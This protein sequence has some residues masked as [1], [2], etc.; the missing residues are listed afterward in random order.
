MRIHNHN[1][2]TVLVLGLKKKRGREP[3]LVLALDFRLFIKKLL[4][5]MTIQNQERVYC[6]LKDVG[7]NLEKKDFT[8]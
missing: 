1:M 5:S 3:L 8:L 4:K 7:L 2:V 6:A